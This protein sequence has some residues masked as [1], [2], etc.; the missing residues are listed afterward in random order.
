MRKK[1][2]VSRQM[3][4]IANKYFDETISHDLTKSSYKR[5]FKKFVEFCREKGFRN[6]EEARGSIQEYYDS[7]NEKYSVSSCHTFLAPV[8]KFY[9]ISMAKIRKP[10]KRV[11]ANYTKGRVKKT[12]KYRTYSDINHPKW[13]ELVEFQRRCGVRRNELLNL[14]GGDWRE[15]TD[16]DGNVNFY[17]H[18]RRGKGGKQSDYLIKPSDVD[19][20][21]S[22]FKNKNENE[23]IFNPELFKNDLNLHKLR[24]KHAEDMYYYYLN[25]ISENPEYRKTLERLIVKKWNEGNINPKTGK[26]KRL[27]PRELTGLY[28]LRGKTREKA[29]KLGKPVTYDR[30]CLKASSCLNLGHYRT[31]ISVLYIVLYE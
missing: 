10:E 29:I 21:K 20:I 5:N 23:R 17:V 18:I 28:H 25:K 14:C 31:N 27:D 22:Y 13:K 16:E 3:R 26:P 1:K 19:L 4:D 8:T 24:A 9:G 30:L 11:W 12:D 6:L 7:L 2:S 15:E